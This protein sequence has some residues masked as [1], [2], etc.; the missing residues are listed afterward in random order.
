MCLIISQV[1][2]RDCRNRIQDYG[3]GQQPRRL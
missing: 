3:Q 2:Q 1:L